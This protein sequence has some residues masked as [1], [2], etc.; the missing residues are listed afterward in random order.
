MKY[1]LLYQNDSNYKNLSYEDTL[2][3]LYSFDNFVPNHSKIAVNDIAII[4]LN[5]T[6]PGIIGHAKIEKIII[7]EG[8]KKRPRCP[9]CDSANVGERMK[10]IPRWKC[11][12]KPCL[13]TFSQPE[14][15]TVNCITYNAYL[16][17]FKE[18][19]NYPTIHSIKAC[20]FASPSNQHS[21][22]LLD[23]NKLRASIDISSN[24][25]KELGLLT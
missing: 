3:K 6:I 17:N 1:F 23:P 19:K 25:K 7:N 8:I 21:I 9:K 10:L 4:R 5:K 24:I 14:I 22:N 15:Q 12:T 2:G 20:S 18:F 16:K 13:Y 11:Y